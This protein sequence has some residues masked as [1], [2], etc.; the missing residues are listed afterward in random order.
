MGAS[1]GGKGLWKSNI[2]VSNLEL[3]DHFLHQNARIPA[4]E[5]GNIWHLAIDRWVYQAKKEEEE[6][7]YVVLFVTKN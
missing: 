7:I 5:G 1:V 2:M 3:V 6:Q 4:G